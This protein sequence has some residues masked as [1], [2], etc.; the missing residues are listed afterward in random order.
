MI[1][2]LEQTRLSKEI[3][4][5]SPTMFIG[6]HAVKLRHDVTGVLQPLSSAVLCLN[7]LEGQNINT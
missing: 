5:V 7:S 3:Y 4:T 6:P 1:D 2:Q